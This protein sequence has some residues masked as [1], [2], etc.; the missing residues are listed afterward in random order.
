MLAKLLAVAFS[1]SCL[2]FILQFLLLLRRPTTGSVAKARGNVWQGR[3]YAFTLALAPGAKESTRNHPWNFL[4]GIL[5][6]LGIAV[7]F[8]LVFV[9]A[10]GRPIPQEA[11]QGLFVF[12]ICTSL[13]GLAGLIMRIVNPY[14]RQ[15]SGF[16]DFAAL[17]LV[18]LFQTATAAALLVPQFVPWWYLAT[19]VLLFYLPFSKIRH[20]PFWFA[21]RYY[22]GT[23]IGQ[24]GIMMAL[25]RR[26]DFL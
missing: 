21:A 2:A 19:S 24:R 9:H 25:K 1:F 26:S 17:I 10:V 13:A 11:S 6:H 16:D 20:F 22:Y 5:F 14:L 8:L 15:L 23:N 18:I 12:L 7:S 3:I 4:R